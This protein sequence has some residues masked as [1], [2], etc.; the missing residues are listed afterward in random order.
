M[1]IYKIIEMTRLSK[2]KLLESSPAIRKQN[3]SCL[4]QI[5]TPSQT[6]RYLKWMTLNRERCKH[7]L[8]KESKIT[9]SNTM[10]KLFEA[11][12]IKKRDV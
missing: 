4:L 1:E 6:I 10:N 5:L 9:S 11:L 3:L 7:L 8:V 12:Y 2:Q